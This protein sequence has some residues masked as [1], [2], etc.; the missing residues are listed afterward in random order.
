MTLEPYNQPDRRSEP[1]KEIVRENENF[2][3]YYKHEKVCP[4]DQYAKFIAA[5]RDNLPVSCFCNIQLDNKF[6]IIFYTSRPHSESL[7]SKENPNVCWK[8]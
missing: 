6:I 3:T 7:H 1:Y 8:S 4:E 5:M 2:E